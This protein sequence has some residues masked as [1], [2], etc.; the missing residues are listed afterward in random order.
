MIGGV[1]GRLVGPEW[2]GNSRFS[3]Y[4]TWFQSAQGVLLERSGSDVPLFPGALPYPEVINA[5][6]GGVSLEEERLRWAKSYMNMV[7]GWSNFTALG[8]PDSDGVASEPRVGYR[9]LE[10]VRMYADE[11]LGEV[12]EFAADDLRKGVLSCTGKR[13]L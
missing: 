9:C 1:D 10:D 4:Y 12:V 7:V 8:C 3:S 6:V 5:L 13:R 2:H 11:L